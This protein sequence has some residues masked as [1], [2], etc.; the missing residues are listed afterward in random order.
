MRM[1][2]T[3][4]Q[5]ELFDLVDENDNV[6]GEVSRK[7]ANH[8]PLLIHRAIGVLI[9]NQ[10]SHL[11]LQQRSST[12]DTDPNKWSISIAG[13]VSK[14][15]PYKETAVREGQEELGI[16]T[17]PVYVCKHLVKTQQEA[18]INCI[19]KAQHNGPFTLNPQE[20]VGGRFF[21]IEEIQSKLD[22]SEL[23]I[24]TFSL[25]TLNLVCGILS[26]DWQTVKH[27]LIKTF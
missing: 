6:I 3:D 15:K 7:Q 1:K 17:K 9:F 24:T 27:C 26:K 10:S 13:H 22:S 11:F 18:E 12:K 23:D 4:N 14:G 21:P 20:I 25:I 2:T 5:E 19:F 16:T 8:N